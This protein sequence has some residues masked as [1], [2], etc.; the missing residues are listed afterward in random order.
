MSD[1]ARAGARLLKSILAGLGDGRGSSARIIF[2][3]VPARH[4]GMIGRTP[5]GGIRILFPSP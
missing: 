1:G 4:G 3:V 2:I 5:P